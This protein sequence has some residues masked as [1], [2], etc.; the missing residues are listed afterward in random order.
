MGGLGDSYDPLEN[1]GPHCIHTFSFPQQYK[2]R[3]I[4][5]ILNNDIRPRFQTF[6]VCVMGLLMQNN[7]HAN[8]VQSHC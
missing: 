1:K 8:P 7:S 3:K 5:Q 4:H 2:T 6:G